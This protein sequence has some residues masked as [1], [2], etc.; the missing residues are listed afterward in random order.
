MA[1]TLADA[2]LALDA[3]TSRLH[4][5]FARTVA[6][7]GSLSLNFSGLLKKNEME[8]KKKKKKAEEKGERMNYQAN[9]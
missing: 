3:L 1:E 5:K 9:T 4:T 7:A 2:W 8:M 6:S